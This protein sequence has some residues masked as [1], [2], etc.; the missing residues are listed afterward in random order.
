[1]WNNMEDQWYGYTS[2]PDYFVF[3]M[4]VFLKRS[5]LCTACITFGYVTVYLKHLFLKSYTESSLRFLVICSVTG[6]ASIL[7]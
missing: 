4:A 5:T 1:M 2:L 6:N 7:S 3:Q